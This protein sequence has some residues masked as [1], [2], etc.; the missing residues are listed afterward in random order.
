MMDQDQANKLVA[1]LNAAYPNAECPA[2]ADP[3]GKDAHHPG[4]PGGGCR[5][6]CPAC[7]SADVRVFARVEAADIPYQDQ[8]EVVLICNLCTH[9][10]TAV[11]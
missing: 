5:E 3:L 4:C 9:E 11:L 7:E 10:W 6:E 1:A 2:C 8:D